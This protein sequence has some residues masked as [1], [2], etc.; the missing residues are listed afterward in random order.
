MNMRGAAQ[1]VS[2]DDAAPLPRHGVQTPKPNAP[3]GVCHARVEAR[4]H[5]RR[6]KCE[7]RS[8]AKQRRGAAAGFVAQQQR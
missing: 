6:A 1:Q 3:L 2:Q 5:A 8:V 4:G 7:Q